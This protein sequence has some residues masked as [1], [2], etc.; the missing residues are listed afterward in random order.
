[1]LM[2]VRRG[3]WAEGNRLTLRPKSQVRGLMVSDF[4]DEHH[5]YMRLIPEMYELAKM[6]HPILP[7]AA[8]VVFKFGTQ[9]QGYWN[10][11]HFITQ[12]ELAIKIEEFK[13]PPLSN[14]LLFLLDQ[15]SGRR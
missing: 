10:N 5:R 6:T 2:K 4:I 14:T 11:E 3:H 13:Y 7:K 9:G 12:V 15:S 8:T 1:M